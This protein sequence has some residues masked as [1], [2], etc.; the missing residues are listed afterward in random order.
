MIILVNNRRFK[1]ARNDTLKRIEKILK[2][3]GWSLYRLSK[4]AD[5]PY[6]S[7]NNLFSRNNEPSI[8][9]LRKICKGL[10]ISIKDFFDDDNPTNI[11]MDYT[12]DERNLVIDYR[13]L[14]KNE[15]DLVKA[16]IYGIKR[17]TM[18]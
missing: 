3:R 12:I 16:Y 4:E 7:L 13:T 17:K 2:L 18:I 15:K 11:E 14:T 10:N 8:T 5:I 1:L 9:T 6:S